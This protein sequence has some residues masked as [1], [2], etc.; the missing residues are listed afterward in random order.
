MGT[1]MVEPLILCLRIS[2]QTHCLQ[3]F[4]DL[5]GFTNI[6]VGKFM[7]FPKCCLFYN[8]IYDV[9]EGYGNGYEIT[10]SSPQQQQKTPVQI[11]YEIT[12]ATFFF[13]LFLICYQELLLLE[14]MKNFAANIYEAFSQ[15]YPSS[16]AWSWL[17][18]L[19][20]FVVLLC[21]IL[22]VTV[23]EKQIMCEWVSVC[24]CVCVY[25]C[26]CVCNKMCVCV[27]VC[28]RACACMFMY[29][30]AVRVCCVYTLKCMLMDWQGDT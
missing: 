5:K 22:C 1:F 6:L 13:D 18:L 14:Q 7:H 27:C 8:C 20:L 10:L 29:V 24:V 26:V 9:E 4:T 28:A 2:C 12:F 15:D 25:V 23:W 16:P 3:M 11:H 30:Y 17:C 21:L 19:L